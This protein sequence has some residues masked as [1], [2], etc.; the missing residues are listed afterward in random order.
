M[1]RQTRDEY[2]NPDEVQILHLANRCVRRA[3]CAEMIRSRGDRSNIGASRSGTGLNF[4]PVS[5]G[6]IV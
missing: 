5:S 4:R 2:V 3:F 6:L 1:P